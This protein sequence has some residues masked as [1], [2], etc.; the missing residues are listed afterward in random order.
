MENG[1]AAEAKVFNMKGMTEYQ[2]DSIVSR[3]I[4]QSP[5]GSVNLFAVWEGQ[6]ISEH[7]TPC[8]A[9]I[10]VLEGR[11]NITIGGTVHC[12]SK[13]DAVVMPGGVPHSLAA[14]ENMKMLLT[15]I[16]HY[17]EVKNAMVE[18]RGER[19]LRE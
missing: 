3:V 7:I 14:S 18:L 19:R 11:V 10:Y 12:L 4:M 6:R 2:R 17:T 9:L 16:T 1:K 15:M 5:Q 13:G 8:N